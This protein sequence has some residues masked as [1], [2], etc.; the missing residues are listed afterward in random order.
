[1]SFFL[2]IDSVLRKEI[3][4]AP[5]RRQGKRCRKR[6]R[7]TREECQRGYRAAL[8]KCSEDWEL[9]A[10]LYYKLRGYYRHRKEQLK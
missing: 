10:W 4:V 1:M 2:T 5:V 3:S 6:H 9:Y 7:F 8:E